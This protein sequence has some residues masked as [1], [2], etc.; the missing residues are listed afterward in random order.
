MKTQI[1]AAFLLAGL[2]FAQ[3][4]SAAELL[5]QLARV[6]AASAQTR[7]VH[8][9]VTTASSSYGA[10]YFAPGM[11]Q[12]V[13]R[14]PG[15]IDA[16]ALNKQGLIPFAGSVRKTLDVVRV[17]FNRVVPAQGTVRV[18]LAKPTDARTWSDTGLATLA[19][20]R[21]MH[22]YRLGD[23]SPTTETTVLWV[24]NDDRIYRADVHSAAGVQTTIFS[25]YITGHNDM[26]A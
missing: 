10:D 6:V 26:R 13:P 3:P 1:A 8:A 17:E 5:D 19:D 2:C 23:F 7:S 9:E 21:E 16:A 15:T 18:E 22:T 25:Q 12:L 11:I 4:V 24:G 14:T 20:G